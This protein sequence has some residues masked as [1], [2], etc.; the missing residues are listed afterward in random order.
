MLLMELGRGVDAARLQ[1]RVLEDRPRLQRLAAGGAGRLEA[2]A[3]EVLAAARCRPHGSVGGALVAALAVDDH[4]AGQDQSA[5]EAAS[6]QGGE[7]ARGPE[8][9]VP[10]VV[11]GL[12]EVDAEAQ[13]YV[14]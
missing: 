9:V 14:R 6:G 4:A 5:A 11:L 7:Q 10:D 13:E 1:R 8:V 12:G 3:L 2:A